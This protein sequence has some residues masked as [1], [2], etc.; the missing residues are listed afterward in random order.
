[1]GKSQLYKLMVIIVKRIP[2][3][4]N[5]LYKTKLKILMAVEWIKVKLIME[6]NLLN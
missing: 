6:E 2:I 4:L 1:M 3:E 5:S